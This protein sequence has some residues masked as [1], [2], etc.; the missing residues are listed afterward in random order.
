MI[1]R[2]RPR[3]SLRMA[4][5]WELPFGKGRQFLNNSGGAV[6]FILG[7]W[8]TSHILLW[9]GGNLISFQDR[10]AEVTGDPRQNVPSGAWFNPAVFK[11]LPAYTQRTN[12]WYYGGLRGPRFWSLDSTLVKYFPITERMKVEIRFEFYNMPNHFIPSDPDT[13]VGSGTMGRSTWVYG[14]N[15]GREVQYTARFHF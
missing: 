4:G 15:Y 9:S 1:D 14:G 5:V 3:H 10:P 13:T 11:V 7:G 8:A 6:D 12:D 2:R